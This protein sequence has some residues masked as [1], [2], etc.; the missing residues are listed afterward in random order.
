M[1]NNDSDND[2][3]NSHSQPTTSKDPTSDDEIDF[4]LDIVDGEDPGWPVTDGNEFNAYPPGPG[5]LP[6]TI[7]FVKF[8]DGTWGFLERGHVGGW[9]SAEKLVS[10]DKLR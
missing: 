2:S 6:E 9:I 10:L 1:S 7:R 3:T 4:Q 8:V 5:P